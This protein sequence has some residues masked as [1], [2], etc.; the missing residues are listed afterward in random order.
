MV[1]TQKE[2]EKIIAEINKALNSKVS[3]PINL[4]Q[5]VDFIDTSI[6]AFNRVLGGGIPR[7]RITEVYGQA[8]AGKTM[9][10]LQ[11]MAQAQKEGIT[12]FID[13]E[14]AI[15]FE[16]MTTMGIDLAQVVYSTPE[17][18]ED[19]FETVESM[20]STG[21][22]S[23]IVVDSVA[24]LVP[25][26][27]L[28][29]EFGQAQMGM[30]ARLMSQAMRKLVPMVHKNN[31]ALVFINQLRSTLG[32]YSGQVTTGGAALSF[33][34]SLRI[35]L[36]RVGKIK[37]G[38][39]VVG[40]RYKLFVDKNKLAKPNASCAYTILD[41]GIS[42]AEESITLLLESGALVKSSSWYKDCKGESVAQ[43]FINLAKL[44]TPQKEAELTEKLRLSKQ[45][46][47]SP[48]ESIGEPKA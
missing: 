28:D 39:E 14:H 26:S 48:K 29:G 8:G 47:K 6:P 46:G 21:K 30:Q 9:L 22:F 43:G 15:S 10:C 25:K 11:T 17:Y 41:S 1:N 32:I 2:I 38:E 5:N 27:E 3:L 19:A 36:R 35:N 42:T 13:M 12:G 44:L 16:R 24:S 23:M 40:I 31:V 34:C 18:A 7:G 37:A 20:V 4:K 45:T 33:Y